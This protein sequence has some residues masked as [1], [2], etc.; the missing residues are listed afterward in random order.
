MDFVMLF[1][2]GALLCCTVSCASVRSQE[3]ENQATG[4]LRVSQGVGP[5]NVEDAP[6]GARLNTGSGKIYVKSARQF[7]EAD[8]GSGNIVI[9]AV[10]GSVKAATGL[11]TVN[12]TMVGDPANGQRDVK[13][14]C[15]IGDVT[16]VVPDGLGMDLDLKLAYTN[17]ANKDF[18]IVS[19][20]PLNQRITEEWSSA[21]GTPRKYILGTGHIGTG[22]NRITIQNI[23]GNIYLKKGQ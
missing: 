22:R 4:A 5:I 14:I 11:G 1:A 9:D 3:S 21:E 18:R 17:N 19:D 7:V 23:N 10:D 12:V 16:L 6:N 13:I 20:F 2:L 8:T 15:S